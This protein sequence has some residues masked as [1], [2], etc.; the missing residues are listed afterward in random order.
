MT[1]PRIC[2]AVLGWMNVKMCVKTRNSATPITISGVTS[3]NSIRKFDGP[4]A[5]P[6]PARQ[7]ERQQHPQRD[8]DQD[9]RGGQLEAL[10]E[11]VP[12][13]RVVEDG[14]V[15]SPQYQR[16]EKPAQTVRDRLSLN[17]NW[18]AMS[19]GMIDQAM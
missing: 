15:G 16:V 12:K 4:R 1:W 18:I 17:E 9:V 13:L 3:G 5:A 10:V 11:G 19:T 14:V 7:A 6:A 8:G 2:A